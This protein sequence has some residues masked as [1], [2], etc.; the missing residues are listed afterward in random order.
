M[1]F[2]VAALTVGSVATAR[3]GQSSSESPTVIAAVAPATY[4][5]VAR[6]SNA[7][8]EVI[9]EVQID[10]QGNVLSTKVISGHPLLTK[11]S[12]EAAKQWKFSSLQG[13]AKERSVRLTFDFRSVDKGPKPQYELTTVFVPPYKVEVQQHPMTIDGRRSATPLDLTTA[14]ESELQKHVGETVTM[15]GKFS[16]YGKIAPFIV[17]G[18]RPIYIKPQGSY[19]WGK[20]YKRMEGRDVQVTGT[21]RFIHYPDEPQQGLAVARADDHFYFDLE[22]TKL[23]MT[24]K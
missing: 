17:V 3:Y 9:I 11:V 2:A 18:N 8:G 7:H 12:E 20:S 24:Q 21:L 6:A 13:S 19:S 5:P 4:P 15:H 22:T 14:S 10:S 16:L 1:L 23:E